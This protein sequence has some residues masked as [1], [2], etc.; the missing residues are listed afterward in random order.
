MV[1]KIFYDF[2]KSKNHSHVKSSPLIPINDSSLLFI[3][4]GMNQFKNIFLD[5]EKPS[6]KRVYNSQKCIRVS[7]KHNDLE[8]V[9]W[10]LSSYFLKCL[11]T[12]HLEITIKKK[13]LWS[14][15]LFTEIYGLDKNRLWV[16]VFRM[17]MNLF[18]FGKI[19]LILIS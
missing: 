8:E 6:S 7:G 19:I 14:W 9:E 13:L 17:M 10:I 15:E 11:G 5:K 2:F 18:Q 3:N 1:R 12:G 16:T 4:A